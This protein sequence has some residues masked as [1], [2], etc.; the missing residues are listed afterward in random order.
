MSALKNIYALTLLFLT[1]GSLSAQTVGMNEIQY[2]S[3]KKLYMLRSTN[4]PFTGRAYSVNYYSPKDTSAIQEYKYGK[5]EANKNY[6]NGKIYYAQYFY[7]SKLKNDSIC[8]E[9]FTYDQ[10]N[11]DTN[12]YEYH[13]IDK[14]KVKWGR[15]YG[16]HAAYYTQQKDKSVISTVSN[17]RFFSRSET[18][19]FTEYSYKN[20]ASYDSAGY[21][22]TK[23]ATGYTA[24]YH[25]NG[26]LQTEGKNCTYENR[27]A[28]KGVYNYYQQHC[29]VW[30][31]YNQEGVL[32]RTDEYVNGNYQA[33]SCT[34][35]ANGAVA[36]KTNYKKKGAEIKMPATQGMNIMPYDEYTVTS[37]SWHANGTISSEQIRSP[38]GEVFTYS[39]TENGKPL[40]VSGFNPQNKPLGIHKKWDD[41]GRVIDFINYSVDWMDTICYRAAN[42]KITSLNLRDRATPMNWDLMPLTY[43]G[44]ETN[45][46][47][48]LKSNLYKEFWSNGKLKKEVHLKAGKIDGLLAHYDEAGTQILQ[49]NFK[50]DLQDGAWTEWYSNGKVKKSYYYVNGMRNGSCIEYYSSGMVKW[51][52][53]YVNGVGG[54]PKAY[55]EN[56]TALNSDSYLE[57]FYPPSCIETQAKNVRGAALH[58]YFLD[59]TM[60]N[61]SVTI[62][63]SVVKDYTY[64]VIAMTNL[65]TPGYDMCD[66]N[67]AY[68]QP[69]GF[70][71]YHSCFV[72]SK[73]LYTDANLNKIKA[74]FGRHG[75]TM[76]KTEPS[77]NPV[78][79]LEKEFL[80]YYSGKQ[81]LNKQVI[82]D[83]LETYLAPR[84]I[85]AKQ[86]YILSVD[87]NVPEGSITGV[88]SNAVITSDK[89][90]SKIVIESGKRNPSSPMYDTFKSTT[91]I[92]YDDLT[93]DEHNT[94][95][96]KQQ[97]SYWSN[98]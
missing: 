12:Y 43:Y 45:Q 63:D 75:M 39:F 68:A 27:V 4:K 55:S 48:Y 44:G 14:K 10:T 58:Y 64:K 76:D 82:I 96:G 52:N 65:L 26:K 59:T 42:G 86:G 19:G 51:E 3:Q 11:G 56:G 15:V 60:S 54:K 37:T 40:S 95:Y 24:T 47:L 72:L 79:G 93:A 25:Y 84:A 46:Y 49:A 5:L 29:G 33:V 7:H 88:G 81:M 91:Y 73:S 71:I 89:G 9:Y 98:K 61:S 57:A 50:N 22:S 1:A 34:Y 36:T 6:T 2:D 62:P 17:Y 53:T 32:I 23:E 21:H 69:D 31:T 80:V 90:Y 35:H 16:Y 78:L 83:S 94:V 20:D 87:N 74:F 66:V 13:W 70:D 18:K 85:D 67:S 92:I 41:K 77:A 8:F 97:M 30:K 28:N 38:K